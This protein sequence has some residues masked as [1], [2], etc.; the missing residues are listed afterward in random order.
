MNVPAHRDARR[1]LVPRAR[2][3]EVARHEDV[4]GQRA[5]SSA[6]AT[7][8]CRWARRSGRCSRSYAGGVLGGKRAEGV[9]P[10]RLLD[11]DAHRRAPRRRA[12][13]T[14]RSRR[15]GSL[16][17]TGAIMVMDETDCVVEAAR[18]DGPSSTR[19]SR[20]ASARRAAR[21]RGGR[22]R[23]LGRLEDGYGRDGGPPADARHGHEHPVPGVLRARR[24]RRPRSINS[25]LKHFARRVRGA[26]AARALPAP[27]AGTR[28]RGGRRRDGGADGDAHDR[29][30]GGHRAPRAR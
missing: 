26:R 17:G 24:R 20:A 14:S 21:A 5:R 23:V 28:G 2:H 29:R 16:L 6:P 13:T 1:R 30:Q 25:S 11:A 12:S 7:T 10:G 8:R 22:R 19:T 15:P 18:A 9:D 27:R 4:H 3:R